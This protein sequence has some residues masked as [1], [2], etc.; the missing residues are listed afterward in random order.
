MS[1][2]IAEVDPQMFKIS[3]FSAKEFKNIVS[4]QSLLSSL[5]SS[6]SYKFYNMAR[7]Y[8]Q[9]VPLKN[10]FIKFMIKIYWL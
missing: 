2:A 7:V 6:T 3:S 10:M 8:K 5:G 4:D 9:I 1:C